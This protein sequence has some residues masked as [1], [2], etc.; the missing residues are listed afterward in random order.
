MAHRLACELADRITAI[1]TVAGAYS[2]IPGGCLPARPV[3]VISFHGDADPITPYTGDNN[4]PAIG[5]WVGEW[6]ARN[7][8][9]AIPEQFPP[10][11]GAQGEIYRN[12]DA[13]VSVRLYTVVGGGHTWPGQAEVPPAF[14]VG[15]LN[16]ELA[17]SDLLW[18]FFAP[19]RLAPAD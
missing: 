11:D 4:L 2:T 17:A 3:P 6:A 1:G 19:F 15:A 9:D 13:E 14:L 5:T 8:C 12:C 7:G 10:R 18:R 16:Q